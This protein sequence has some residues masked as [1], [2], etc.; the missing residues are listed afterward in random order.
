MKN[1]NLSLRI[2]SAVIERKE[3]EERAFA[4][5][6]RMGAV[7]LPLWPDFAR[8]VPNAVLRGSLFAAIQSKNRKAMKRKLI[9][10]EKSLK[11]RF[12]GIQLNQGDL[13]VWE[14]ALHLA[15]TQSLG[16]EIQFSAYSFL[17]SLGKATG[18]SQHEWLKSVISYL[19]AC[20]VEIAHEGR[21]YG[22][23]LLTSYER[24]EETARYR[25]SINPRIAMLYSAGW[26]GVRAHER[27]KIGPKKPL[28][29]WLHGYL[30]SHAKV[31]PMRVETY[32]RLSG[33][34]EAD[35]S[36]FR[37]RLREALD[38]LQAAGMVRRHEFGDDGLVRV[39]HVPSACQQRRIGGD[40]IGD[41]KARH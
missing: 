18:K 36:G 10:D 20:S 30:S 2:E 25:V 13:E 24:E 33:S 40:G 11:I 34:T 5:A 16:F 22:G 4:E 1:A 29:L 3:A 31:Y 8:G 6:E 12:T 23:N 14:Q 39:E 26:T 37:R 15:R 35:M 28:A 17:K 38:V 9:V 21:S 7:Q 32:H 19:N 27:R 41:A